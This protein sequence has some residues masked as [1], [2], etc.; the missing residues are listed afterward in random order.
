M[1]IEGAI[2]DHYHFDPDMFPLEKMI[3]AMDSEGIGKIALV[4]R[5]NEPFYLD[6]DF[7]KESTRALRTLLYEGNSMGITLY[8]STVN[9]EGN[10]ALD[11]LTEEI[12][13][14]YAQPDNNEVGEVIDKY[15][16][17]FYGW[18]FVNPA[19][20]SDPVEE[21]KKYAS[22]PQMIGV[23][24]HPWWHQYPIKKLE[25][26]AKW[27][28]EN[29]YPIQVHLGTGEMGDYRYLPK[30]FPDLKIVY[31]HAG[32]PFF[33]DVWDFARD[34]TVFF[35]LSSPYVN[36]TII[37]EAVKYLGSGRCLYGTD[38][39]YGY[40][41]PGEGYDYILIKGWIEELPIS[42]DDKVK[43]LRKNFLSII[44]H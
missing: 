25:R 15:P 41:M 24:T 34:F 27:C 20:P 7:K 37:K 4:A 12:Y 17:R 22:I 26:V 11:P 23:K 1:K 42:T 21:I 38:G 18:I 39:P 10:F 16:D 8:E 36:E 5:M 6:T 29:A 14:I 31:L 19:G 40:Q 13:K 3:N 43:I 2:D 35:D 28:E 30:N 32:V 9:S 44:P 33:R